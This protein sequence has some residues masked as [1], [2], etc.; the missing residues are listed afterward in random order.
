M[1]VN[2]AARWG[3]QHAQWTLGIQQPHEWPEAYADFALK[4]LE[5]QL[6]N[7]MLFLFS[8]DDIQSSAA[9]TCRI[10]IGSG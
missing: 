5:K 10:V 9:S 7:P 4:G 2:P 6:R 8:E 3:F 1:R